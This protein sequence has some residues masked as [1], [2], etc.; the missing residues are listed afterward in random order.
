METVKI[1]NH[2]M[3]WDIAADIHFPPHF[4]KT[5]KYP[6]IISAHPI[7]SCKEQTSGNVY[8]AA[9]AKE[10][11]VVI[12]FDASFQG[13]S[14]GEPRFIED[15]TLRVEDFRHVTD[16]LVTLPYVDEERIGV[17]GICGGG[18]YSI[19]AA[20]T[21]RRI[22]AVGTVTGANYGRLMRGNF[23]ALNPIAALEAMARQRTAEARGAELHVDNLLAN[24][25]EEA[26]AAGITDRDPL[27]ATDY[28]RTP[29]GQKP[30]GLNRSLL[31]HQ[32]AAV[33]WDAFH[34]AE[35][36]LTQPLCIVVGDKVGAFGAYRDGCEI[37]ERAAS[38]QKELVLL[39]GWSHYDLYDKE[40][41]VRLALAKLVPFY[42]KN[43]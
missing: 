19:N 4:D 28:Y 2:D 41:P 5:K 39:E 24:S 15:P 7:G 16:Y 10:G 34:L 13:A 29:R 35:V 40:E 25:V 20:M 36:L 9:L 22:K 6:A 37:I 32:A 3:Y 27:E 11:F 30:N 43:L 21:E 26:R 38:K 17:L 12:A 18:G 33:G 14:G 31:S 42:K 1:H 23:T 8:G